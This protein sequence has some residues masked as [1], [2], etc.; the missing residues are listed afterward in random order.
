M[1]PA[2]AWLAYWAIPKVKVLTHTIATV[3]TILLLVWSLYQHDAEH[4]GISIV[5]VRAVR[6][7]ALSITN[8]HEQPHTLCQS[9][10]CIRNRWTDPRGRCSFG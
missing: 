6:L 2:S 4:A 9:S 3:V 7:A 10:A 8:P 1:S 5:E